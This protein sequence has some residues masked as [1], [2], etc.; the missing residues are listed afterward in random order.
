MMYDYCNFCD[1]FGYKYFDIVLFCILY[2]KRSK[3]SKT[4]KLNKT[5]FKNY[6]SANSKLKRLKKAV[7]RRM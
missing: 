2:K 6:Y 3:G 5:R 7:L 4:E 1:I